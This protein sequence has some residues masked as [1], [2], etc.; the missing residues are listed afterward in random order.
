M[1]AELA[2]QKLKKMLITAP[3]MKNPDFTRTFVLQTDAS[4]V[5]VGTVLSQGEEEDH[6]IA[7]FS[8]KLL[9]REKSYSTVERECLA[10]VLAVKHFEAYLLGRSFIIQ[11]DHRALQW[12]NQFKE[13]NARLTRWS[14]ILQLYNFTVQH[15]KGQANANADALSRLNNSSTSCQRRKEENVEN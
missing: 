12:L 4:G 8:Q 15:R 11:T 13:K 1:R 14:L 9:P 3:L 2:F 10:I 6:P 5:G 7:Y